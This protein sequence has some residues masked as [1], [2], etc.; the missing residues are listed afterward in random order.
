M[1]LGEIYRLVSA[2]DSSYA[3]Y[4]Y[5]DDDRSRAVVFILGQ[6][7][8]FGMIPDRLRLKALDPDRRYRVIGH[9]TY[10]STVTDESGHKSKITER[11]KDYGEF[12]GRGLMN[13]GLR[14]EL[15]GHAT[16]QV[17]V[18]DTI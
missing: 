12:T 13:V 10:R 4:E 14:F 16:S 5:L 11:I 8:Q 1:Q 7:M 17:L 15:F 18:V 6:N 3:V 2:Y 9:G